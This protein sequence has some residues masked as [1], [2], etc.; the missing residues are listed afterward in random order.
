M[1][2]W[3]RTEKAFKSLR[4]GFKICKGNRETKRPSTNASRVVEIPLL[5]VFGRVFRI[6]NV[7]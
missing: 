4:P 3:V 6:S 1:H 2:D 5:V 7:K